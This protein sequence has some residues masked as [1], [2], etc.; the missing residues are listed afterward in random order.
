[1]AEITIKGRTILVDDEDIDLVSKYSWQITPQGYAVTW[2]RF[3]PG[4]KN[5]KTTGMHRIILGNP[6]TPAIDHINR[7][8]LDNRKINLLPCTYGHNNRNKPMSKIKKSNYRGVSPHR[9]GW[10]VVVRIDGKLKWIGKYNSEKEAGVI[11]APYF[12]DIA[13]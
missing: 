9:N 10:Q 8:P 7:N 11:A 6:D 12:A 2:V 5:R 3:A 1:M 4:R 13:P